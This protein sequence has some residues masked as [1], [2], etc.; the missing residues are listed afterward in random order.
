M[1][2]I[3]TKAPTPSATATATVTQP[4]DKVMPT[5]TKARPAAA[6]AAALAAEGMPTTKPA[7]SAQG[8][9][10]PGAEVRKVLKCPLQ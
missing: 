3:A 7:K 5:P 8:L 1:P 6:K 9:D 4:A 10:T 2:A